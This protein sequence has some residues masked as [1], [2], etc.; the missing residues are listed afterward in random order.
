VSALILNVG[1]GIL[2]TA[3]AI[4]PGIIAIVHEDM[5]PAQ[6]ATNAEPATVDQSAAID[7]P[8]AIAA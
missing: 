4:V 1:F 8:A 3:I 6:P 7:Q 5:E 2:T